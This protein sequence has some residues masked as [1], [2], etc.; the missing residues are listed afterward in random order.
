MLV[1]DQLKKNDPQLRLL[2]AAVL[3]G[4]FVLLVGLWWVQI[5]S[6]QDFHE[7]LKTQAFRT[8]RIP[9]VRGK[10]LDRNGQT[11]AENAPTYSVSLYLDDLRDDFQKEYAYLRP[12]KLVTN[13]PPFWKFWNRKRTVQKVR[14]KLTKDQISDLTWRAR[15]DV[16]SNVVADVA[17]R[18]QKPISLDFNNFVKHY[19]TRLALP[20]PVLSDIDPN[21]VARFEEQSTTS[22]GA[23]LEVQSSRYYPLQTTASHLLGHLQR[24]D[25]SSEGEES[26]FTYRLPDYRGIVGIEYSCDS[27]LHGHAGGKSVLVNNQGYR[28]SETVWEPAEQG[29]NVVLTID[30]RIQQAAEEALSN[31][32]VT[33]AK[34]VRGAAVVMDVNTG[35]ILALASSPPYDPNFYLDRHNFPPDYYARVIQGEGAEKNR[36]TQENYAPGSIFKTIVGL[37]CLEAGMNPNATIDNP[38]YIY[39]GPH[40]KIGDLAHPGLYDFKRAMSESSN[41]YFITNGLRYAKIEGIVRL[42][43]RL[44][45]GERIGLGNNQETPGYFPSWK[46]IHSHWWVGDTANI[47]IGQ[48]YIAVTPLQM[49]VMDA[50]LANGGKVLYPRLIDRIEPADPTEGQPLVMPK[51]VVRDNLGVSRRSIAIL[52][53]AMRSE[54]EEGTGKNAAI[55]GF[56]ICGKTGT[57]EIKDEHGRA[58]GRTTW[59]LSFAPMDKPRWAVVV[60]VENGSFGGP[61]CA[62]AAKKIY[63]ALLS[64]QTDSPAT[65]NRS[66]ARN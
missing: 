4:L 15:Y 8:V 64:T 31:A 23:D 29:S 2:T 55:P 63:E 58:T 57:A 33:Y 49:T 24:D 56:P 5:V 38:G 39:I 27:Y 3:L 36:A 9:A 17:R 12:E 60:M 46:Q 53:D 59:F 22:D 50:A 40:N 10:I 6:G 62:P 18:L 52:H 16:A 14:A 13:S 1:F 28:Q 54:V 32:P 47:C 66:L 45:L 11:L 44:H 26:Y 65:A 19:Q 61:T 35:D 43:E 34:P 42:G 41:T 37:A 21:L 7:H 25:S 30:L 51:G 20:Y 48:G